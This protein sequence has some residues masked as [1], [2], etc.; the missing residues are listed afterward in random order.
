MRNQI[1]QTSDENNFLS[2]LCQWEVN[3]I[4]NNNASKFRY[5]TRQN[6]KSL[7]WMGQTFNM[8]GAL[9]KEQAKNT[10]NYMACDLVTKG[11]TV[12]AKRNEQKKAKDA[13]GYKKFTNR[14]VKNIDQVSRPIAKNSIFKGKLGT[15][16]RN[17]VL[18]DKY[19]KKYPNA[20]Q[21]ELLEGFKR[22]VEKYEKEQET[23]NQLPKKQ[24][25]TQN[26][27]ERKQ[28]DGKIIPGDSTNYSSGV[29]IS[30]QNQSGNKFEKSSK[31]NRSNLLL[32]PTQTSI[33]KNIYQEN[34]GKQEETKP[35]VPKDPKDY[36]IPINE[37]EESQPENGKENQGDKG[38][39]KKE[40]V[41]NNEAEIKIETQKDNDKNVKNK[42]VKG[43]V[44]NGNVNAAAGKG[45]KK[46]LGGQKSNKQ[47]V[48]SK[49]LERLQKNNTNI[50]KGRQGN[51]TIKKGKSGNKTRE[52]MTGDLNYSDCLKYVLNGGR[53]PQTVFRE[54]HTNIKQYEEE[55]KNQKEGSD[56]TKTH[57]KA[58]WVEQRRRE[59]EEKKEQRK[60]LKRLK[61][62]NSTN[63]MEVREAN[64]ANEGEQ[65]T[66]E[67]N[68]NQVLNHNQQDDSQLFVTKEG[69]NQA[70][71]QE[72]PV[73]S[74]YGIDDGIYD[75]F[76]NTVQ[77]GFFYTTTIQP[78]LFNTISNQ[79]GTIEQAQERNYLPIKPCMKLPR[80]QRVSQTNPFKNSDTEVQQKLRE[81]NQRLNKRRKEL[82]KL[83]ALRRLYGKY[84]EQK[85][86]DEKLRRKPK[87]ITEKDVLK[88]YD[89]E[90]LKKYNETLRKKYNKGRKKIHGAYG[91]VLQK[92][93]RSQ[94]QFNGFF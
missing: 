66:I 16:V 74:V 33:W 10:S 83:E 76:Y 70:I 59:N 26:L 5:V 32:K 12:I 29:N 77:P 51:T 41:G 46:Q 37:T 67:N 17:K 15:Y 62:T 43:N 23:L 25:T 88:N 6:Q 94:R 8:E 18:W 7:K 87:P 2:S 36:F 49:P 22:F 89:G 53:V 42:N 73:S 39:K 48:G 1:N 64:E 80:K 85:Y 38:N 13:K 31:N 4:V 72:R 90:L 81:M 14:I 19:K 92:P 20:D 93:V 35:Y 91:T 58:F 54:L 24:N 63:T 82:E 71:E 30:K 34:H 61:Q 78:E 3:Q 45:S 11:L 40:V 65:I 27:R 86:Y 47:L 55:Q 28:I 9:K 44:N 75:E 79:T 84:G 50:K 60:Q 52:N 68:A 56:M 69:N 57:G 21:Q